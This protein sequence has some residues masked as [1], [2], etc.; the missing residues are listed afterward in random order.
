MANKLRLELDDIR[1]DSFELGAQEGRGTVHGHACAVCGCN[2]CCC[3]C[4]DTCQATCPA[5]CPYTCAGDTC[6]SCPGD[7][8][9]FTCDTCYVRQCNE[10]IIGP[11]CYQEPLPY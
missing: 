8:C 2:P 9:A 1:V 10:T 6:I 3:T 4:C 7:T 5:T 11:Y